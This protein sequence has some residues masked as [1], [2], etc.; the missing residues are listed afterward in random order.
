MLS[1]RVREAGIA[2][3]FRVLE[4]FAIVQE[5]REGVYVSTMIVSAIK[6]IK[7][8]LLEAGRQ[9]VATSSR[10]TY[11]QSSVRALP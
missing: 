8:S 4:T 5:V 1:M 3:F 7:T 10:G 2:I 11:C 9:T 6:L